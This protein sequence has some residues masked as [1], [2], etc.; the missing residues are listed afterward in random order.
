MRWERGG[1]Y[2]RS[3]FDGVLEGRGLMFGYAVELLEDFDG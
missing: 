3:N 2:C 1:K